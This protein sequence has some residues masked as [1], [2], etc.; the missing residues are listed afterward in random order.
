MEAHMKIVRKTN[1]CVNYLD[2]QLHHIQFLAGNTLKI[3]AVLTMLLDHTC[4][5]VLQWLLG[6]YWG[7][8]V[9][10]GAMTWEQFQKLDNFIRFDLQGIGTIAFP[11]FCFF[12]HILRQPA[13]SRRY[14]Y[15]LHA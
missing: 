13:M 5:I 8:M 4:K 9:D 7:A 2:K 3:I 1:Q 12:W 11:L 15:C 6:H 10:M 14:I